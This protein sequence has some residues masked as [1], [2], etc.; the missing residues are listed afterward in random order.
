MGVDLAPTPVLFEHRLKGGGGLLEFVGRIAAGD[1]VGQRHAEDIAEFGDGDDLRQP[2]PD[3][4][5]AGDRGFEPFGGERA[6]LADRLI[7][8]G[9]GARRHAGAEAQ[10]LRTIGLVGR[11]LNV[12]PCAELVLAG[13]RDAEAGAEH[14][15]VL[16]LRP[17]GHRREADVLD[18][19]GLGGIDE[20]G[21]EADAV[22][23]HR[24]A[25][26]RKGGLAL[27]PVETDRAGWRSL[28][29]QFLVQFGRPNRIR[30][31]H[32]Q[33]LAVGATVSPCPCRAE[34]G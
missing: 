2:G 10:D 6:G 34:F 4:V 12:Q 27:V 18:D 13:G 29:H 23:P 5:L 7:A 21:G 30:R 1:H 3:D 28:A 19:L 22:H 31:I 26:L 20:R 16:R 24:G 9:A 33:C 32:Q 8:E 15:R 14:R 17:S 25:A 11:P